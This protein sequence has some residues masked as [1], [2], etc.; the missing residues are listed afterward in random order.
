MAIFEGTIQEFHHFLGPRVRNAIN[1]LTKNYRNQKNGICEQCGEKDELHS[2]HV[3]GQ[4]RR[5]IIEQVLASNLIDEKIKCDIGT[6]EKKILDAHLPIEKTFKFLCH[7]CHVAY[8]S[9]IAKQSRESHQ[10]SKK[11]AEE[12]AKIN[13]IELWSKRPLQDNHKIVMAFLELEKNGYVHLDDL[14]STC[15]NKNSKYY[16]EKFDG[17]YASMKTDS[18]NSHGNVFHDENGIVFIWPRVREEIKKHFE[19]KS[20]FFLNQL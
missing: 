14:K 9:N 19:R 18:G 10:Q 1:G 12:F 5:L 11:S 7:A 3:Y 2:A 15:S 16:V 4:G 13:K 20:Y 17:H 6:I 8:N